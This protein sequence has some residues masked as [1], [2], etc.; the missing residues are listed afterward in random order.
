MY[1]YFVMN[2]TLQN[3]IALRGE[4]LKALS[5]KAEGVVLAGGTA[6]SLFYFRHRESFDLDFFTK[7][8]SEKK[9][10]SI[11]SEISRSAETE[12][13]IIKRLKVKDGARIIVCM[14]PVIKNTSSKI[15]DTLKSL[16]VDFVEDVYRDIESQNPVVN[17]I[18]IMSQENIY[19]RKIYAAFGVKKDTDIVGRERFLGGRQEAKDF[20]D[21]YYL[22][23][24]FMPLSKFMNK[25]CTLDEKVSSVTW[26]KRYDR[27]AMK[28][29]LL[30]VIT[31]KEIDSRAIEGHFDS[32]IESVIKQIAG[33]A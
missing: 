6:L 1:T 32:E 31:D 11:I 18:S 13:D 22:S 25:H 28:S 15:E 10:M 14:V 12:I 9:V 26:H 19:L 5:G 3:V 8:F 24:T 17:G 27:L 2:R 20:F 16:K 33:E 23:T 21:L 7:N 30:D 29:E 4:V